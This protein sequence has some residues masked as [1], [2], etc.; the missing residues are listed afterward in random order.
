MTDQRQ[1]MNIEQQA[2]LIGYLIGGTTMRDGRT[3]RETIM[4]LS[5]RDVADLRHIEARLR[6]MA[7]YEGQI[8]SIVT[9]GR[10]G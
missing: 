2:D 5:A 7:P 3:A 8:K 1:P 6:R 9:R 4:T 10:N